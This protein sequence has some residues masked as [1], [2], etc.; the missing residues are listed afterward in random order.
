MCSTSNDSTCTG[1]NI[2]FGLFFVMVKW[3]WEKDF[4]II[5]SGFPFGWINGRREGDRR[6]LSP[7]RKHFSTIPCH[8]YLWLVYCA[9]FHKFRTYSLLEFMCVFVFFPVIKSARKFPP[10]VC[11]LPFILLPVLRIN[12]TTKT[13]VCKCMAFIVFWVAKFVRLVA[14]VAYMHTP[15]YF[16]HILWIN[17]NAQ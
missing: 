4:F 15:F 14:S 16:V 6:N 1:Q 8:A 17:P 11:Q 5:Q 2:W 10:R 12:H 7:R 13:Y 9:T 3:I